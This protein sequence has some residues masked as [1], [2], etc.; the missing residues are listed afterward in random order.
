MSESSDA[1][2]RHQVADA[3]SRIAKRIEHGDSGTEQRRSFVRRQVVRHRSHCLRRRH[4]IFSVASIETDGGYFFELAENEVAT[5][6]RIALEAVS[7]VPSQADPLASFPEGD[8]GPNRIDASGNLMARH[9]RILNSRPVS[10]FHQRVA[11]ADAAS[12][13]LDAY[14]PAAGLWN[15]AVHNF[16]IPSWLADLYGLMKIMIEVL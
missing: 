8:V 15:R 16:K 9:S 11:V 3:G 13:H 14:L 1:L 5:A 2:H 4:H 7:A 12:F 10:P 6:A